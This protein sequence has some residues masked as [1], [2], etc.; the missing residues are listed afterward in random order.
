[1]VF[2]CLCS[3]NA[4]NPDLEFPLSPTTASRRR[5][6]ASGSLDRLAQTTRLSHLAANSVP[7][8]SS[9]RDGFLKK[10]INTVEQELGHTDCWS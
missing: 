3:G 9:T 2:K 8:R 10:W 7:T 5:I 1:M 6:S 4:V